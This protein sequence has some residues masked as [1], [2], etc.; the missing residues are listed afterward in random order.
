MIRLYHLG[1]AAALF[2]GLG[3]LSLTLF[4]GVLFPGA[5]VAS[6]ADFTDP[7]KYLP[8]VA[9]HPLWFTVP[10]YVHGLAADVLFAVTV[11]ALWRRLSPLAADWM[12]LATGFSALALG[13]YLFGHIVNTTWTAG[14]VHA[15]SHG[16]D[17]SQAFRVA[18]QIYNSCMMGGSLF[19]GVGV[20]LLGVVLLRTR[21]FSRALGWSALVVGAL[22]ATSFFVF[23]PLVL[24]L[25]GVW[26]VWLGV[27]MWVTQ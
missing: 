18:A 12:A 1:A 22:E 16:A 14:L 20:V 15:Y 8:V 26:V 24:P 7:A 23:L 6:R 10:A 13:V 25:A 21:T 11:L 19:M 17:V 27:E 5:G 3:L 9:A 4:F 2:Q